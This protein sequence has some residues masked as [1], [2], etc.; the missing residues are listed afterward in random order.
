MWRGCLFWRWAVIQTTSCNSFWKNLLTS[1][2]HLLQKSLTPLFNK[3]RFILSGNK[4]MYPTSKNDTPS[5]DKLRPVSLTS[6]L[7]KI[8][9]GRVSKFVVDSIRQYGNQEGMST[10]HCLIDVHHPLPDR[11]LPQTGL[12][13]REIWYHQ[14]ACTY[15]FLKSFWCNRTQHHFFQSSAYGCVAI[16]CAVGGW[17]HFWEAAEGQIQELIF[18]MTNFNDKQG[19]IL[20]PLLSIINWR[21]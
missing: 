13:S 17:L 1:L 9:E 10:T 2:A 21:Q 18:W 15:R 12:R 11:C 20:A 3:V 8:A 7:A 16:Y 5:I 4:Q 14:Y 6:S 19:T